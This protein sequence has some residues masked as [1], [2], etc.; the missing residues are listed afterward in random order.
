MQ[1]SGQRHSPAAL[2]PV[3][4]E[5]NAGGPQSRSGS[6]EEEKN[7]QPL[8]GFERQTVPS[9]AHSLYQVY[10]PGYTRPNNNHL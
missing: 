3:P 10:Y 6:Y 1:A 5:Q 4:T 8:P 7:I 2:P 9:V